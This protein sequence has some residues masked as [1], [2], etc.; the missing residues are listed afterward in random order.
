M[1]ACIMQITQTKMEPDITVLALTGRLTLG[2]EGQAF[3]A[4]LD[5]LIGQGNRKFILNLKE[6][7]Y[8]DSAGLGMII[9]SVGK[10]Q[11]AGGGLRVAHVG[12]RV[13]QVLKL[14]R[15][16]AILPLDADLAAAAAKL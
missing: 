16:D 13:M 8:L 10:V 7:D 14:T 3:E 12:S 4:A 11:K 6:L 5:E 9:G 2:R 15:T 1:L